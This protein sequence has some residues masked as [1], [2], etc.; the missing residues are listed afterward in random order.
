MRTWEILEIPQDRAIALM[1]NDKS[2]LEHLFIYV[3]K[4]EI[5]VGELVPERI[6]QIFD[7][8]KL[9]LREKIFLAYVQGRAHGVY[10]AVTGKLF[11]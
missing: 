9:T 10:G 11:E 3:H 5:D 4:G 7:D 8:G 6:K 2:A 1:L